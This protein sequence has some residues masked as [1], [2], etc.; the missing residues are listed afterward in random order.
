MHR[1]QPDYITASSL[2]LTLQALVVFI[3]YVRC[4]AINPADPGIMSKFDPSVEHKFNS[5]HR[6]GMKHQPSENDEIAAGDRSSLSSTSRRSMTNMSKKSSME[7]HD[8]E[9]I[10]GDHNKSGS[11]NGICGIFCCLFVHEDCRKQEAAVEQQGGEDALFCTLCNAEV[12]QS[13]S[14]ISVWHSNISL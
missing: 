2:L 4:T 1:N 6:I 5:D 8:G 3:L 10:S 9:D 12:L 14:L 7:Y 11:C 13:N